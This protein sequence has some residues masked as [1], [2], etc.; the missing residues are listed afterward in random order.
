M[1]DK[2]RTTAE[3]A[4]GVT[5]PLSGVDALGDASRVVDPAIPAGILGQIG[6][7]VGV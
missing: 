5:K 7:V 3:A 6:L 2:V 4:R 1:V